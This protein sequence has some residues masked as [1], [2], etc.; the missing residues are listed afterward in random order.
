MKIVYITLLSL[1]LS[2][3]GIIT[4][5]LP[6][7]PQWPEAPAVLQKKCPDLKQIEGNQIAITDLLKAVVTNYTLYYECSIKNDGWNDWYKKQ[8]EIY[9]KK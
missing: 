5:F 2:S 3:C 4:K 6:A 9:D 8:K 1:V 7:K